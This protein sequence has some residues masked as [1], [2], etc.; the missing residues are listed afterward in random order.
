VSFKE[1]K[2][3]GIKSQEKLGGASEEKTS[4]EPPSGKRRSDRIKRDII[5]KK[6]LSISFTFRRNSFLNCS[7]NNVPKIIDPLECD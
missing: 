5:T 6:A 7:A 2:R 4:T 1:E 3:E